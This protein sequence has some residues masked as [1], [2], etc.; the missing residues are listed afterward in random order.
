MI[1]EH[2]NLV[3]AKKEE[4]L[5]LL[6]KEKTAVKPPLKKSKSLSEEYEVLYQWTEQQIQASQKGCPESRM[7]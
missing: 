3:G 5:K 1:A 6:Y 4:F 7:A 2:V